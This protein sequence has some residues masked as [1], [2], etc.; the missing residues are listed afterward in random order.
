MRI[1]VDASVVVAG[2]FKDGTVRDLLLNLDDAELCAPAY[3]REEAF[4]QIPRVAA[5]A[6]LSEPTVRAVLEDLFG[7]IDLIPAGA[8]SG[9]LEKASALARRA[10]A[11]R[12]ADYI[13]LAL[14]LDA[15]IWSLDGD[16]RR[17][18][19]LRILATHDVKA[20]PGPGR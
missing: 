17:V 12:D 13:A 5:R 20:L 7:A 15:P 14:A 1:I 10:G 4:R 18:P 2:L 8:Y 9:W 16:L 3:I 6:K 19:G 11:E